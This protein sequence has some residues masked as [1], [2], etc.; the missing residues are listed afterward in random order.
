MMSVNHVA[1]SNSNV[2][3]TK[4]GLPLKCAFYRGLGTVLIFMR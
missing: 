2:A 4:D 1:L 3:S